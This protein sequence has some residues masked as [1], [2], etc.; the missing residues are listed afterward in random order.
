[1]NGARPNRILPCLLDRLIDR[2]PSQSREAEWFDL[3][4]ISVADGAEIPVS[5]N[6]LVV[7]ARNLADETLHLRVF[8]RKGQTATDKSESDLRTKSSEVSALKNV[9][10]PLWQRERLTDNEHDEILNSV[11]LITGQPQ[12]E[13]GYLLSGEEYYQSVSRDLRWLFSTGAPP[14]VQPKEG[15]VPPSDYYLDP[16]AYAQALDGAEEKPMGQW[17]DLRRFP[18]AARSVIAYGMRQVVTRPGPWK[19]HLRREIERILRAFEP[20][21]RAESVTVSATP[22][23]QYVHIMVTGEL[24]TFPDH[25]AFELRATIDRESGEIVTT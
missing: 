16:S 19:D 4:L 14:E 1:M 11:T 21:I 2:F 3:R 24:L 15:L 22:N 17:T 13:G 12:P 6:R 5:G 8:D 9:L 18:L 23:R 25:R 10:A 20:R 7:V